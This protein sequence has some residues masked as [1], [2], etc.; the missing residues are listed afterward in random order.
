MRAD[1]YRAAWFAGVLLS[2]SACSPSI[3]PIRGCSASHDLS[4][5]CGLQNPEDIV[6]TPGGGWLLISQM[7]APEAAGNGSVAAYEPA[8]GRIETLFPVGEFDD[9][10][11]WGEPT[12]A[13][14][15]ASRFTPHGID[16]S[17][18]ADGE[19]QLLV[20]NH[21]ERDRVEYFAVEESDAGLGLYWRGCAAAPPQAYLNDVV[22]RHDGGFWV[23]DS[24]PRRWR[25]WAVLRALAFGAATGRVWRYTPTV[26]FVAEPGTEMPFPNGI[27]QAPGT[28]TL[29]VA[30]F[31]G[32]EVRRI[33]AR[34]GAVTGR[35]EVRH[36]DNLS[37][38]ADGELLVASQSDSL[39]ALAACGD[40]LDGSCG[41]AFEVVEVDPVA[42]TQ[43]LVLAHEG[44]PIGGVSAALEVG[45]D[46]YLG[47]FAGNR[48][49]RWR[50]RD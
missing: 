40:L 4:P 3:T 17:R 25:L 20:V 46:L 14:P 32:N 18:R 43:R 37:W 8:S 10:R 36:P 6:T 28:E 35:V 16:L 1:P 11:N 45:N 13:P 24:L 12:C 50:W 21:A 19:L 41:A 22:A 7:S 5:V 47:T 39:V 29:Y 26:G 27:A 9:A 38:T 44:A 34:A 30:S 33:D 31:F 2:L 49:A 23:T 15:P 48:I 42:L